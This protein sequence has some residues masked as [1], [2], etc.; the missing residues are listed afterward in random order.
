[1]LDDHIFLNAPNTCV[2]ENVLGE[3]TFK[4]STEVLFPSMLN[5]CSSNA[6]LTMIKALGQDIA[7]EHVFSWVCLGFFCNVSLTLHSS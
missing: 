5:Q 6:G 2:L 4:F 3:D 7:S 1:M